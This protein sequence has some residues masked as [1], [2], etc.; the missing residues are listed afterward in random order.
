MEFL[1]IDYIK[2]HSRICCDCEDDVLDLYGDSA[3]TT[4]LQ[5]LGRTL[6]DLMES[7]NGEVPSPVIH[8]ALMLTENSYLHR[9]PSESYNMSLVPYGIDVLLKPYMV[10]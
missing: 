4:I 7:N 6:D 10:L 8:A 5:L 9:S 2:S 3:E 1:T